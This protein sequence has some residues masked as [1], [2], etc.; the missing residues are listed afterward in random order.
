MDSLKQRITADMK[1]AMRAQDKAKLIAIRMILAAIKQIEVDE[2]TTLDDARI[3]SIL[4]KMLK[5]RRES[6]KQFKAAG[7]TDL[8]A[9]EEAEAVI[10]Q[11]YL[12]PALSEH[13][14]KQLIE[15]TVSTLGAESIK[16]M[17]KI[18]AS[19]KPQMLGRADMAVVSTLIKA[20]LTR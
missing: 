13:E 16:D 8:I 9:V 12:P 18:M 1:A 3:T 19:L 10:I 6:S 5:Q 2:R 11:A 7:R 4:D 14:I 17:G 15:Q 20:R